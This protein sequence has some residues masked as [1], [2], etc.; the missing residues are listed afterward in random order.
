MLNPA[1]KPEVSKSGVLTGKS[2]DQATAD[3][4]P[5]IFAIS[6][7]IRVGFNHKHLALGC[8]PDS[9]GIGKSFY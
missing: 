2:C 3:S 5:G 7:H 1:Y 8:R 6:V 9:R 4:Q